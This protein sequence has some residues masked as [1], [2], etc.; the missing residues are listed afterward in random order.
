MSFAQ[1]KVELTGQVKD[2]QTKKSL[3]FCTISVFNK[4]DS[5]I[6][7]SVTDN[8]GFFFI[9]LDR[10]LYR[11]VMSFI[12][13][14]NDTIKDT[15]ITENTFLGIMKLKPDEK[16][17][18][19]VSINSNSRENLVDRDV[20]IVTEKLKAGT[21][22]TK[23]VLDKLSGVDLDRYSN[24]IKVDNDPKV[25]ILVDGMEKDQEY[26]KNLSPDRLK[27]IEV[28]R[29]PGGRYALEG[30]S[31]VINII[32]K[33]D[34]RGTEIFVSDRSM[35]DS[36]A[37]KSE[38]IPV[39]NNASATFN[40]TYNKVNVYAKG[41]QTYNNF[42][43]PSFSTKLYNYG[44]KIDKS[45][46]AGDTMNTKVKQLSNDITIGADYTINPK[47]S[48]SFEST[49][50]MEPLKRN[51]S[52]EKYEEK[53]FMNDSLV[54]NYISD[55]KSLSGS[56]GSYYSLFYQGKFNEKNTLNSNFTFSD[57]TS[58][59]T[60]NY[61][62]G[63]D[64]QKNENGKDHKD[65]TEFYLEYTHTFSRKTNI[66]IGYGNTYEKQKNNFV[67]NDIGSNFEYQDFR[68]KL[69]SYFSWQAGK[70]VS[71]KLGGA[72]ES[73]SPQSDD[74]KNN[75]YIIE[76]YADIKYKPSEML[77]LKLKYRSASN[78]PN[79]SQTNPF[80]Y[81]I[82]QQSTKTGNPLLKPEVTNKVSLEAKVM[83]GLLS[84]EPYYH[85]SNNFITETGKLMPDS[86]FQY[87][88]S[89]IGQYSH[90]GLEGNLTVPFGKK[91]FLQTNFN[92][93][94]SSILYEKITNKLN[95]F[96]MSNQLVYVNDKSGLVAG[97]QYQRSLFRDIT[98]Q[99]Y[100]KSDNDFWIMF[101]Q[102]TFLKKKL[103]VML[104]YFLPIDFGVDFKQGSYIATENYSESKFADIGFLKNMLMF[105][106]SYRFNK[107]KFVN[108][109]EKNIEIKQEKN[110][111]SV[112]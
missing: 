7:A 71:I 91:L 101:I 77:D 66:Q 103:T 9:Q 72:G 13:Y 109:K 52:S 83:N 96:T 84:L 88:Y 75:Y 48:I 63:L 47:H 11:F 33:K 10:G 42:N 108:K 50:N 112:M 61:T 107:G 35:I 36:D 18:K 16:Y 27:K 37:L 45:P 23:E 24:T 20:Q 30:Y 104:L 89:N 65:N 8:N 4:K 80:T 85:F 22:S 105:E 87:S 59:Y 69:Y 95:D 29:D 14:K 56:T 26:I 44:L 40:Y 3:E 82:D 19:E 86:I 67:I 1:V 53:Y 93:F 39:Q 97:L 15:P 31:A 62:E 43:L 64:Y 110:N 90:Y 41:S 12:G 55:Y 111:K 98:A 5:L 94:K 32:L 17:L 58:N 70:K 38:Y 99:G 73:S 46:T 68:N 25:M 60:N 51:V 57:Y 34:Y 106:V 76:P 28:I 102:Q 92:F 74:Q 2:S 6:T 78:Y 100:N 54:N 49:F 79:I 21:T 81:T